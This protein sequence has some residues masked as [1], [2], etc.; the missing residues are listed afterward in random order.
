MNIFFKDTVIT[1]TII[2]AHQSDFARQGLDDLVLVKKK[3]P[4]NLNKW[5]LKKEKKISSY[6]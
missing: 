3:T 4:F 1:P 6:F 2:F 5:P